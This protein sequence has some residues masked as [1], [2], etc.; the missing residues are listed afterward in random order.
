LTRLQAEIAEA[1]DWALSIGKPAFENVV[2]R[3]GTA[4]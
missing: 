2:R 3:F 4:A 1:R